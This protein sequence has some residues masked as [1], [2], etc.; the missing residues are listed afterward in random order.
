M[1][2]KFFDGS[3]SG[4]PIVPSLGTEAVLTAT[5]TVTAPEAELGYS[6]DTKLMW[7]RR[8]AQGV[9]RPLVEYWRAN[10]TTD[11]APN[12]D[13]TPKKLTLQYL[14][15]PPTNAAYIAFTNSPGSDD[16]YLVLEEAE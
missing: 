2:D 4:L 7:F 16:F 9:F 8:A 14:S 13:T 5:P 3:N 12:A 6:T 11:T 15:A 10:Q 1:A